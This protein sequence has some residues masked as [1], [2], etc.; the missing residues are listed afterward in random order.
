MWIPY[1]GAKQPCRGDTILGSA[2]LWLT[3][4]K[5]VKHYRETKEA[6]GLRWLFKK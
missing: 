1:L 6:S 5:G 2:C 4:E 3:T